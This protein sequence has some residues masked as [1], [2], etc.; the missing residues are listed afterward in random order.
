MT[1]ANPPS[2]KKVSGA[3]LTKHL[4]VLAAQI[5]VLGQGGDTL[6]SKAERL[7]EVVWERALGFDEKTADG[8]LIPHKP[9]QWAI[10]LLFDRL[11]G[12]V[13]VAIDDRTGKTL[14]DKVTELGVKRLNA[15]AEADHDD[16][17]IS[18]GDPADVSSDGDNPNP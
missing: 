16:A 8:H 7:A 1:K 13:P 11:E 12:R 15:L 3:A 5:D 9:E 17:S 4:R 6:I 10:S 18:D 2:A 14:A